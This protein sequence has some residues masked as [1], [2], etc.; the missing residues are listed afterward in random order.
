[1]HAEDDPRGQ[2]R[3]DQEYWERHWAPDAETGEDARQPVPASPY[4]EAEIG[5]LRPSTAL[6]AGCGTGTE[7]L[8]LAHRGWQV[9]G[10]DISAT[11][12]TAAAARAEA[13]GLTGRVSWTEADLTQWEPGR[14]WDLVVTHYAHPDSGQLAFYERIASWVAPGGTLLIVGHLHAPHA[15]HHAHGEHGV[16]SGHGDHGEHGVESGHGDHGELREHDGNAGQTGSGH[17]EGS[18]A[19]LAGI[20]GLFSVPG[21]TV[22]RGYESTRTMEAGERSI[23]LQDVV[24][25]A[26]RT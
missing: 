16:D 26:T 8:W 22:E 6:D 7:A 25:R 1:M 23:T 4:L 19:T 5:H 10:A 2:H 14:M 18:T 12:L 21:W 3:F 15:G 9:T 24:V 13:E 17:P 11:A 20:T